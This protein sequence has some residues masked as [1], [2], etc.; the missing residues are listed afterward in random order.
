[1]A[2]LCWRFRMIA[3]VALFTVHSEDEHLEVLRWEPHLFDCCVGHVGEIV[4][5]IIREEPK[6]S[7]DSIRKIL[8]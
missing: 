3:L 4:S 8:R 6:K 2:L 7:S 5:T 1:M